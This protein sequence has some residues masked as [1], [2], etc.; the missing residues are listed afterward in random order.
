VE[1]CADS[2]GVEHGGS[3]RLYTGTPGEYA[4]EVTAES[5]VKGENLTNTATLYYAVASAPQVEIFTPASGAT[6]N[7]G[8]EVPAEYFCGEGED[9]PGLEACEAPVAF[10]DDIDT[11]TPGEYEFTV[12]ARSGDGQNT[13]RTVHYKVAGPPTASINLVSGGTYPIGSVVETEFSC[14]PGEYGPAIEEC[15]DSNGVEAPGGALT[16]G[17]LNTSV[18]GQHEYTVTARGGEGMIDRATD[19][20]TY[21]V[22]G[23][24]G[25]DTLKPTEVTG[26]SAVLN[27]KVNPKGAEVLECVIEFGPTKAYGASEPC[28]GDLGSG[29]TGVLVSAEVSGL[30]PGHSYH[31]RVVAKNQFGTATAQDVGF[32]TPPLPGVDTLPATEVTGTSALA[33]A[34]VNPKGVSVGTACVIEYGP[35]TAY[36]SRVACNPEELGAGSGGVLVSAKLSPLARGRTYHYRVVAENVFGS[37]DGEDKAFTTPPLPGVDTLPASDVSATSAVLNAKVNPKGVALTECVIEYGT[38]TAYGSSRPCKLA[39]PPAGSSPTARL[40]SAAVEGLEPQRTY[41]YR[42]LATSAGGTAEGEDVHFKTGAV[43]VT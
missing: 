1:R 31:Y 43:P 8:E 28:S 19:T 38:S 23:V 17:T 42:V 3:G 7:E 18:L 35:T 37:A 22:E 11:S 29:T 39:P 9:E 15:I 30:A 40:A 16:D 6:Y 32:S 24:P 25:V 14:S 36:G 27:A 5:E 21:T 26:T 34:K 10:G 13:E 12:V 33:N 41:H 2:N 4:Y 20:I